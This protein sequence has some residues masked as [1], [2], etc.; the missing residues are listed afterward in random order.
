MANALEVPP[1]ER[2]DG[3]GRLAELRD[4]GFQASVTIFLRSARK[5]L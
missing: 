3:E 4:G 2:A 1:I 5:P